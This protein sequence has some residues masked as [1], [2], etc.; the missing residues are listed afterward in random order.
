MIPREKGIAR[1]LRHPQTGEIMLWRSPLSFS[2]YCIRRCC[3]ASTSLKTQSFSTYRLTAWGQRRYRREEGRE[4]EA[5]GGDRRDAEIAVVANDLGRPGTVV[6]CRCFSV[7]ARVNATHPCFLVTPAPEG[8]ICVVYDPAQTNN[9]RGGRHGQPMRSLTR[10]LSDARAVT[11][12]NRGGRHDQPMRSPSSRHFSGARAAGRRNRDRGPAASASASA[13][14]GEE[15]GVRQEG[16]P[17]SEPGVSEHEHQ[18]R[19]QT[20]VHNL[21]YPH[22]QR[23]EEQE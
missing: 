16:G 18:V 3:F 17:R 14:V 4:R 9:N 2:R 19:R 7:V 6:V 22:G 15:E 5:A 1:L 13:L 12:Q 11:N 20:E 8:Y 23:P 21:S 10:Q